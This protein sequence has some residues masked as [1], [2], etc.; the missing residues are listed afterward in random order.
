MERISRTYGTA[1][2]KALRPTQARPSRTGGGEW[3][4]TMERGRGWHKRRLERQRGPVTKRSWECLDFIRQVLTKRINMNQFMV[5]K[6][7]LCGLKKVSFP[8]K[9]TSQRAVAV[10]WWLVLGR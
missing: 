9:E 5:L 3:M 8:N 10:P 4:D 2:A 7:H 6:E 1:R